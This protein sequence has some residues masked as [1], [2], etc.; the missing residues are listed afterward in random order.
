MVLLVGAWNWV[1]YRWLRPRRARRFDRET[2]ELRELLDRRG[3]SDIATRIERRL[4]EPE[5]GYERPEG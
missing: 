4:N 2:A 5:D 1:E 3:R